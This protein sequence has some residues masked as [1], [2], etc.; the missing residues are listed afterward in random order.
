MSADTD[1]MYRLMGKM[2]ISGGELEF[3]LGMMAAMLRGESWGSKVMAQPVSQI[4]DASAKEAAKSKR[5]ERVAQWRSVLDECRAAF[6][7]RNQYVHGLWTSEYDP[8]AGEFGNR[9]TTRPVRGGGLNRQSATRDDLQELQER[10]SRL[11]RTIHTWEWK[12]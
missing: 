11:I 12:A 10:F 9:S 3:A 4:M 7:R 8:V 5:P 6:E 1:E 2:V